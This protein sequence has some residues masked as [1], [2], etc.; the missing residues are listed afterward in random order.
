M[1]YLSFLLQ[2][3]TDQHINLSQYFFRVGKNSMVLSQLVWTVSLS[4]LFVITFILIV[5]K[6]YTCNKTIFIN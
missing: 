5:R 4:L 2:L 3:C 6:F 1:F